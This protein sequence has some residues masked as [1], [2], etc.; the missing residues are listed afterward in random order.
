LCALLLLVGCAH[1]PAR[2]RNELVP[3][4]DHHQHL[5]SPAAIRPPDPLLPAVTLPEELAS[6][7]R[8]RGEASGS[9]ALTDLFTEDAQ[10]LRINDG[11]WVRGQKA[12]HDFLG[13]V[14]KGIRYIPNAYEIQGSTGYIAGTVRLGEPEKEVLNFLMALRKGADGKWRISAESATIKPPPRNQEPATAEKLIQQLDDARIER[15]VVLSI[16]YWYGNPRRPIENEYEKVRAENDWVLQ[17]TA[18]YP[19][20]LIPFC[21]VNPLKDYAL[22]E[23]ERCA[24]IPRVKGFKL[25]FGNSGVDVKNPQHVEALRRFFRAANDKRLA[26]L[27][28]LWI[29]G[30][31]YGREHS[32]IFLNQILP[33]APDITVQI[34]HLAGAGP[35]YAFDDALEVFANAIAAGDPRTR[36]LYFDTASNVTEDETE[37]TLALVTKRLRQI[38]LGR[39]LYGTDM[40]VGTTNPPPATSWATTRRRLGLTDEEVR[41]LADNVPPYLR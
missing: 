23:L 19:E 7:L 15:A 37:E 20:R 33:E 38:G 4:A 9:S 2:K 14:A 16:A 18:L 11:D 30:G 17:Q 34:A 24:A 8:R 32:D 3:R 35:G 1:A 22:Q 27:A 39:I 28:H 26:I 29:I 31:S 41:T 6:L 40:S 13:F 25:H 12:V 10:I 5:M 21:G 36:N